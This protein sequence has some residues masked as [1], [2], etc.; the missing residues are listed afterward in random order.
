V[1]TR[2]RAANFIHKQ[3]EVEYFT[4]REKGG[5]FHYGRQE[6]RDLMDFIYEGEP[7]NKSEEI[8]DA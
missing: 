4:K 5:C 2:R 7:E 1:V 6:L 8:V 3:F